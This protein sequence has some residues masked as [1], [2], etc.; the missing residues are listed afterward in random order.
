MNK[1][2]FKLINIS[3]I[4]QVHKHPYAQIIITLDSYVYLKTEYDNYVVDDS[5]IVFIPPNCEHSYRCNSD[6]K[7]LIINVPKN[8]IKK[9][10]LETFKEN[11]LFVIDERISLLKDLILEEIKKNPDSQAIKYLFFYLYDRIMEHREI[12]SIAYI[13]EHYDEDIHISTL[14][15]LEHYNPNYYSEWFKKQ[16]GISPSD[17]IQKVRIEKSKEL[18]LTTNYSIGDIAIQVGYDHN[19]SFTRIFKKIEDCSPNAYRHKNGF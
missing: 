16:T 2:E 1:L 12:K 10:D 4:K 17:Y 8:L 11:M 3:K 18:L 5:F 7:S 14:A 13:N 9:D 19:S 15:K 6:T